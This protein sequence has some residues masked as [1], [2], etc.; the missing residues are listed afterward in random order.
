M[1]GAGYL[2]QRPPLQG[3]IDHHVLSH[4]GMVLVALMTKLEIIGL[5][6]KLSD[7]HHRQDDTE[8][9]QRIGHG[10][11][12]SSTSA[13][14]ACMLQGLLRR[15]KGRRIGRRATEHTDHIAHR[16]GREV[17]QDDGQ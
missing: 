17:G 2:G 12:Q 3:W 4:K 6:E 7:E 5:D 10:R 11:G 1:C 15:T 8:D 16:D 14:H 13:S 9:T